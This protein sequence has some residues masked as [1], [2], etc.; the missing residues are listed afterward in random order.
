MADIKNEIKAAVEAVERELTEKE[1][2]EQRQIKRKKLEELRA[3]GRD[4][5]R[6]ETFDVTAWSKDIK[7]NFEAMEDQEVRV[8]GRI[9][10]FRRMGKVAFV[11]MQDKQGRIRTSRAAFRSSLQETTSVRTNT[12]S[13]RHMTRA[14]SSASR[15]KSSRQRPARSA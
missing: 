1:I 8:A 14:T 15:V 13:S 3:M 10:A 12:T 4:P 5:Y 11:D 7:D 2:G 6:E 9:M